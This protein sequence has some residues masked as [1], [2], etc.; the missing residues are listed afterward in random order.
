MTVWVG[1]RQ[2]AVHYEGS[3]RTAGETKYTLRKMVRFSLDAI[4]SF[5]H[6]PL[7]LST[8]FGLPVRGRRLRGHP[9][10]S[11]VCGSPAPTCPDSARITIPILL[12]IGAW[13]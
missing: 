2:T 8:Y 1:F 13:C 11:S 7:Q 10:W 3:A 12:L 6:L 9:P 4:A 5:S